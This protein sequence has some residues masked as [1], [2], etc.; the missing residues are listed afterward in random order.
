MP[1]KQP[2]PTSPLQQH[3]K[4]VHGSV[5]KTRIT[6]KTHRQPRL[7]V[8][9]WNIQR[10]NAGKVTERGSDIVKHIV[11]TL[12]QDLPYVFGVLENKTQPHLVAGL[13]RQ[14]DQLARQPSTPEERAVTGVVA[15]GGATSVRENLVFAVGGGAVCERA[16]CWTDWQADFDRRTAEADERH[17]QALRAAHAPREGKMATRASTQAQTQAR[18]EAV[19]HPP[20]S[21][22]RNPALLHLRL[23]GEP[24]LVTVLMLHAP[25]PQGA[26]FQQDPYAQN[27]MQAVLKTA[28][29]QGLNV[30]QGDGN[31]YGSLPDLSG[32]TDATAHLGTTTL[33]DSGRVS[34]LDR[35]WAGPGVDLS[36]QVN[37]VGVHKD[38]SDHYSLTATLNR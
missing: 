28:S 17:R 30:V 31:V 6:R 21:H 2:S 23:P 25:G 7:Q 5:Q 26:E 16:E 38:T 13:L 20:A 11:S 24:T 34:R 27:Y 32:Y 12:A 4:K 29:E 8:H 22:F 10:I 37:T 19:Q 35:S 1:P 3:L 9:T 18:D 15:L 36:A 33:N 14:A